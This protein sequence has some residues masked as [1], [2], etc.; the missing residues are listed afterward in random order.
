MKGGRVPDVSDTNMLYLATTPFGRVY[1]T[2]CAVAWRQVCREKNRHCRIT[3]NRPRHLLRTFRFGS[4]CKGIVIDSMLRVLHHTEN[5][6][7]PASTTFNF[8]LHSLFF[9]HL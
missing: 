9:F 7:L 2:R 4:T 1:T 6:L 3:Y 5:L 8:I